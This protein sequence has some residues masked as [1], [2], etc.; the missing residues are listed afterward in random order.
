MKKLDGD[1]ELRALFHSWMKK[2]HITLRWHDDGG[3]ENSKIKGNE[4]R[5]KQTVSATNKNGTART[6]STI[7]PHSPFR[8]HSRVHFAIFRIA[9]NDLYD[10]LY[11]RTSSHAGL[12]FLFI[13]YLF[14]PHI[15]ATQQDD[16]YVGWLLL[17]CSSSSSS[18]SLI[19]LSFISSFFLLLQLLS[20][21]TSNPLKENRSTIVCDLK[22]FS[23]YSTSTT[24]TNDDD[25]D[26][27]DARRPQP[28]QTHCAGA[29]AEL[30]R[31]ARKLSTHEK[32][33]IINN[34]I[35]DDDETVST[36]T[37]WLSILPRW[38]GIIRI[39]NRTTGRERKTRWWKSSCKCARALHQQHKCSF[40]KATANDYIVR[41]ANGKNLFH[42]FSL[43]CMLMI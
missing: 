38:N 31:Q 28:Q 14:T 34:F 16:I 20:L 18:F 17:G 37:S 5:K 40:L 8:L 4:R 15:N 22:A 33:I 11:S 2:K 43:V 7:S 21:P 24:T 30:A 32:N 1:S 25:E 39:A 35:H 41:E 42:T 29:G 19:F 3:E 27:D 10:A 12:F 26:D 23:H 36:T 6:H 13:L 9:L